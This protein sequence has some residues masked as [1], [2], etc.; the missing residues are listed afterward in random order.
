MI[1]ENVVLMAGVDAETS[2]QSSH[3]WC[4]DTGASNHMC[5]VRALFEMLDES[6]SSLVT[7]GDL[8]KIPV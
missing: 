6:V 3:I 8:S 5:G 7:F 1:K 4:L 2:R